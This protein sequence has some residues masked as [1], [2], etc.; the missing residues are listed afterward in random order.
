MKLTKACEGIR[1]WSRLQRRITQEFLSAQARVRSLAAEQEH[2]LATEQAKLE[3]WKRVKPTKAA[4]EAALQ[5][6]GRGVVAAYEA[7]RIAKEEALRAWKDAVATSE[8]TYEERE[9]EA[10][11]QV[12]ATVLQGR[13]PC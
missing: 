5:N 13:P 7:H 10:F 12:V 9:S 11:W 6:P 4:L 8:A 3:Y 2:L 1:C